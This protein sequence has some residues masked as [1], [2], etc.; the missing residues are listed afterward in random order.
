MIVK[1]CL[2]ISDDPDDH[3][4]FSEALYELSNDTILVT[5]SDIRKAI[6]LLLLKRCVPEFIILNASVANFDA[7]VFFTALDRELVLKDVKVIV[8]G[9]PIPSSSRVVSVLEMEL[10]FSQLK[11]A[12]K[13]VLG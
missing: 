1:T 10:S 12:L 7:D 3:I 8:Y 13:Q 5:V 11:G 4:E 9:E 2:L 6:D